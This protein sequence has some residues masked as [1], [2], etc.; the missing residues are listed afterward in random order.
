VRTQNQYDTGYEAICAG[1]LGVALMG[2]AVLS[3]A[4]LTIA[5]S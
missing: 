4:L 1:F 3:A 2:V 5:L